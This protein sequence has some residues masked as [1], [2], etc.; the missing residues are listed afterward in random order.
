MKTLVSGIAYSILAISGELAY[1]P[2]VC[3]HLNVMWYGGPSDN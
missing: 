1:F 2:T 3:T